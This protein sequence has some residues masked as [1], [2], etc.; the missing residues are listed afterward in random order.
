MDVSIVI[1]HPV[2]RWRLIILLAVHIYICVYDYLFV[3]SH[4][5]QWNE[6]ATSL[7]II[8]NGRAMA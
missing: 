4:L 3:L 2:L 5:L 8:T 6:T 7:S 1:S